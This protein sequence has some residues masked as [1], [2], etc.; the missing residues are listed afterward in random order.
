M[1]LPV[2]VGLQ[3]GHPGSGTDVH[4]LGLERG[5]QSSGDVGVG[6]A[7]QGGGELKDPDAGAEVLEG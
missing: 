6:G 4:T 3:F 7:Q 2:A 1:K 5:A